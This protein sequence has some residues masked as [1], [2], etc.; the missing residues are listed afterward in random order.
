MLH[1]ARSTIYIDDLLF[2]SDLFD[3][4]VLQDKL[5]QE[6]FLKRGWVFKPS[7]SW[8]PPSQRVR[9]LDLII[10]FQSMKF[11]IPSDE[12]ERLIQSGS[13]LLTNRK[14]FLKSLASWVGLLKSCRLAIG[15][16]PSFV[17]H[18]MMQ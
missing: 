1:G 18:Y 10:D 11:C 15:R 9:Y 2:L 6:I 5:I 8:G 4:G 16:Y 14:S 13:F 7:K 3:L 17:G 12:L